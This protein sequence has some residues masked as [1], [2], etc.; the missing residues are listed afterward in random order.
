ML[1]LM[2]IPQRF[3]KDEKKVE[4]LKHQPKRGNQQ[5]HEGKQ[6]NKI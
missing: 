3:I 6:F 4:N 1:Q 2:Q 5:T